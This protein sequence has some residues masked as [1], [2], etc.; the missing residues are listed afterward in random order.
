M[1]LGTRPGTISGFSGSRRTVPT[2]EFAP[3]SLLDE[4]FA[5]SEVI[6]H[7]GMATIYKANDLQNNGRVVAIK[8][9]YRTIEADPA[10]FS[11]FQSEE[12]IG[13]ELDHPSILKFYSVKN[14]S[15]MYLVMEF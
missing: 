7:G 5:I 6:S 13:A 8:I 4:R 15:R 9:P 10:L 12:K 11:R 3:G 2:G 14:K 1:K